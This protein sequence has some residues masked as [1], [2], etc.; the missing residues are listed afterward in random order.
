MINKIM[1]F[2]LILVIPVLFFTNSSF[3]EDNL[4]EISSV[5]LENEY[6]GL[7]QPDARFFIDNNYT[8]SDINETITSTSN[9]DVSLVL[10]E[11][12]RSSGCST[13]CSVGC[14]NGCSV[15]CSNGCSVGCSNG[16]SVG[17]RLK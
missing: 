17:C 14:S 7:D 2:S 8:N 10:L 4:I 13:G 16:C 9:Y 1:I 6:S 15:G 5:A 3:S 11:S 12:Q